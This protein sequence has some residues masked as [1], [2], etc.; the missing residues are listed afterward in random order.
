MALQFFQD[1]ADRTTPDALRWVWNAKAQLID[2]AFCSGDQAR[3]EQLFHSFSTDVWIKKHWERENGPDWSLPYEGRIAMLRSEWLQAIDCFKR[4]LGPGATPNCRGGNT[5]RKH[6]P[7]GKSE[8]SAQIIGETACGRRRSKR[9]SRCLQRPG[10]SGRSCAAGLS[11]NR[12][13]ADIQARSGSVIQRGIDQFKLAV[14]F[15]PAI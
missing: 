6:E 2:A 14:P 5:S 7:R 15:V 8:C 10:I 13:V 12:A 4:Y 1:L 9:Q 11:G 3:A